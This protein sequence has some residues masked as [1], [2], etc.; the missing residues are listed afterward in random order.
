M[1]AQEMRQGADRSKILRELHILIPNEIGHHVLRAN[2]RECK[3]TEG[4]ASHSKIARLMA[5]IKNFFSPAA[6]GAVHTEHTPPP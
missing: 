4:I 3:C 6:A 1:S 5:K 2:P